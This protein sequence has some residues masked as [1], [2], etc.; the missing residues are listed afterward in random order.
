MSLLVATM[1]SALKINN[2]FTLYSRVPA[3]AG[4]GW[5]LELADISQPIPPHYHK[6]HRHLIVVVEGELMVVDGS[7]RPPL[8][9]SGDLACIDAGVVHELVP[10][11]T[12]QFFLTDL[13]AFLSD[14]D[15]FWDHQPVEVPPWTPPTTET[16]PR[17]DPHYFGPKIDAGKYA[18]YNLISGEA[19]EQRWSVALLEIEESPR[20]FHRIERELFLVVNGELDIEIDGVHQ[21]LKTGESVAIAP[22]RVHQL[23]SAGSSPVRLLCFNFPAFNPEDMHCVENLSERKD[24]IMAYVKYY[25]TDSGIDYFETKWFPELHAITVKQ[26]GFISLAYNKR[27]GDR[28]DLKLQFENEE[29]LD[30]WRAVPIHDKLIK[31]LDTHRSRDYWEAAF[32][33]DADA[34]PSTLE[35]IERKVHPES[36][37][38]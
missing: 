16:L 30:A 21:I 14:D 5:T 18:V 19:T 8:L 3:E 20:H 26:P 35:W 10:Q 23:K 38:T 13:P 31:D 4:Q 6:F 1:V 32:T 36:Y 7:D 15:R 9:R 24:M 28:I 25:L 12:A 17:V 33:N 29:R 22:G 37:R 27:K 34:D 11:G 2:H